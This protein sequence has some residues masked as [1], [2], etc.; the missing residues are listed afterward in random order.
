[1]KTSQPLILSARIAGND[2][3]SFD[4]LRQKHFP[5]ARN[6]LRA[7]LT[8][9]H[10]LPGE[11]A[12]RIV[13]E[14]ESK[15][16]END[17]ITAEISGIRHLG[18]GVAFTITSPQ[19]HH[20]H[21]ELRSAFMPWLGGQDMQRWQPHITVQ[22]KVPRETADALHRTLSAEFRPRP[23]AITG[24]DLWRYLNGPWEHRATALFADRSES[25]AAGG[26]RP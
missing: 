8:M 12:G 10:R 21:A 19:L 6:F 24:L 22:N 20:V 3:E 14:M 7:H 13:E 17:T 18:A 16:V 1:M 5:P 9:F 25:Q 15:A 4:R 23:I 2:L 26:G 11:Y